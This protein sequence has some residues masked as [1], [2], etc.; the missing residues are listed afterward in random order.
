MLAEVYWAHLSF[1]ELACA[2][3]S[4]SLASLSAKFGPYSI[5][6]EQYIQFCSLHEDFSRMCRLAPVVSRGTATLQTHFEA[7]EEQLF[8]STSVNDTISRLA[9]SVARPVIPSRAKVPPTAALVRP[10]DHLRPR[11]AKVFCDQSRLVLKPEPPGRPR[12]CH[13]ISRDN[14][15]ELR[16]KLLEAK[17]AKVVPLS[18]VAHADGQPLVA[19]WFCV[20]HSEGAD[21]LILDRRPQNHGE[22]RLAWLHLPLGC[23]LC[24]VVL[25]RDEGIRGSGYDL[26]T[27][28]SQLAEHE[29][30][31]DRQAVGRC[32]DGGVYSE[33][34]G[35]SGTRSV[36][37]MICLGMGD[38]NSTDVAQETHL[39]VLDSGGGLCRDG[40][41]EW[42]S[43]TPISRTLQGVYIDDGLI[44]QILHR[45]DMR[46]P[47]PDT[48]LMRRA[49][50]ALTQAKLDIAWHKGF[51]S[52]AAVTDG[53][54]EKHGLPVF[55]AWGSEV[56]SEIGSVGTT[57]GKRVAIAALL[58]RMLIK[59]RAERQL[60]ERALALIS[61]PA[62]H[63]RE[64]YAFAHRAFK[65]LHT[66][67]YGKLTPWP[68]DIRGEIFTLALSMYICHGNMRWPVSTRIS[69][70]DATC[71]AGGATSTTVSRQLSQ[72]LWSAAEVK[73]SAT[74]LRR[75]VLQDEELEA[76]PDTATF[77]RCADWAVTRSH[78]YDEAQHVNLQEL[79]EISNELQEVGLRSTAPLRVVNG[80]DSAVSLFAN[81]KGRSPS[82]LI[83]GQLKRISARKIANRKQLA[84]VKV[85]TKD[86]PSDD[87]SR[88]VEL[89]KPQS[90][91]GWL[92]KQLVPES[93]PEPYCVGT[94]PPLF[95]FR[96]AYG[97]CCAL[98]AAVLDIG[99]AVQRPLEAYPSSDNTAANVKTSRR[100]KKVYLSWNDLDDRH[101]L[102]AL[103]ADI[104]L[105]ITRW[106]HF[107]IPC[108][109]WGSLNTYNGGTRRRWC[110]DGSDDLLP[111]EALGNAQSVAVA[112][113]CAL[114]DKVGGLFSV[115]NPRASYLWLSGP[116]LK[117]QQSLGD[118]FIVTDFDQ[119]QYGLQLPGS[120]S[121]EFCRKSTRIVGN[122]VELSAIC[123]KCSGKTPRHQHIH[124]I[125]SVSV[126]GK[127][128]SR[129]GAAGR[130]PKGLCL[131]LASAGRGGFAR[132][133][134][135]QCLC[136][137]P[138]TSA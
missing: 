73:G 134:G 82:H 69:T 116:F 103:E 17:A 24:R 10:E 119:C 29:S 3:S 114:L 131:A 15:H 109:S 70:T 117:L 88:F 16:L 42:R 112:G 8:S 21:R 36:L 32:F 96:E 120:K 99:I 111:R 81:A 113:L 19:G 105:G 106:V 37:I 30:G 44:A 62:S 107:G 18:S 83:N 60:V 93:T 6:A 102:E 52:A 132:K 57:P 33:F 43:P 31:W 80:T 118:R 35:V 100:G 98:S 13:M 127:R 28:F 97:G 11:E 129:A 55:T 79:Q 54:E 4:S 49:L 34:G 101:T 27:Y 20:P 90:P 22:R 94:A 71:L 39:C 135:T 2:Q 50:G 53:E 65:W 110:P 104:L 9:T 59:P 128:I 61:H 51:G 7:F 74:F 124:A 67:H 68:A 58:L 123:L 72:A 76:D 41:L 91:P 56:H 1:H 26:S 138:P 40:L 23:Q 87:P 64:V 78:H 115:E 126:D 130:Y 89:R 85:D 92:K 86:N 137:G 38:L 75:D 25:S 77:F 95:C 108:T 45:A 48:T 122:F 14:E 63:R 66:L 5:S 84:N 46:R 12:P 133:Y 47:G 136:W 125:G 121:H